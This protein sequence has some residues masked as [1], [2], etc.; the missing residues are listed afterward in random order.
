MPDG[1][2]DVGVAGV[3]DEAGVTM[4]TELL[5]TTGVDGVMGFFGDAGVDAGLVT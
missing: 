3:P 1:D 4:P 5:E 2:V